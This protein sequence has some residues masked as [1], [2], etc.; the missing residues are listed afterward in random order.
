MKEPLIKYKVSLWYDAYYETE[1]EAENPEMAL[2]YAQNKL[3][4]EDFDE[5]EF[6]DC[7]IHDLGEVENA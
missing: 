3:D 6:V 2:R 5:E 1:V 7:E 4:E